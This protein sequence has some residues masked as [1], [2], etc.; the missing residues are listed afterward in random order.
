MRYAIYMPPNA[1]DL[2]YKPNDGCL[3]KP[4]KNATA[5][6]RANN[7]DLLRSLKHLM[8]TRLKIQFEFLLETTF[9]AGISL[10][11]YNIIASEL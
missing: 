5:F 6:A 4:T 9:I 10:I 1:K 3:W 7:S 8:E 11:G 2:A